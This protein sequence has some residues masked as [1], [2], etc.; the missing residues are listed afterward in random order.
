MT[1]LNLAARRCHNDSIFF[2]HKMLLLLA[3][4]I[5]CRTCVE[6]KG[7][8]CFVL[9]RPISTHY[10]RRLGYLLWHD[11]T[12]HACHCITTALGLYIAWRD[13]LHEFLGLVLVL[14]LSIGLWELDNHTLPTWVIL[15]PVAALV[16]VI[17]I[18]LLIATLNRVR[19]QRFFLSPSMLK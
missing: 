13:N 3:F 7:F 14:V 10:L 6:K 2:H 1:L 8:I 19:W 17:I 5:R 9:A 18:D 16:Q 12:E 15:N 4:L 11:V